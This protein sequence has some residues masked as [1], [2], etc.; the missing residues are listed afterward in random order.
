MDSSDIVEKSNTDKMGNSAGG[1]GSGLLDVGTGA[2]VSNNDDDEVAS[3]DLDLE[4]H[5]GGGGVV[6]KNGTVSGV[7]RAD[8]EVEQIAEKIEKRRANRVWVTFQARVRFLKDC[9][10]IARKKGYDQA[11]IH[12][13]DL[14]EYRSKVAAELDKGSGLLCINGIAR[15]LH[16]KLGIMSDVSCLASTI[17]R[18]VELLEADDVDT[19]RWLYYKDFSADYTRVVSRWPHLRYE[20]AVA[21]LVVFLYYL[22][23]P[24]LFC[25]VMPSSNICQQDED[26]VPGKAGGYSGWIS[27]IYFASTTVCTAC[28]ELLCDILT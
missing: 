15:F 6:R 10:R 3:V 1:S 22:F 2:A 9:R 25:V 19:G 17:D 26:A 4:D 23:T 18:A 12:Q 16:E 13:S 7:Q 27:A 5:G 24:V 14:L 21:G 8:T 20:L 11:R 28:T